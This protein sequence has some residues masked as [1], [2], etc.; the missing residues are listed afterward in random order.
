MDLHP[1]HSCWG[2]VIQQHLKAW[3]EQEP[4]L[5]AQ[6]RKRLYV[7]DLISSAPTVQETQQQKEKAIKIFS[8]A[9]FTLHKW[10][11]NAV[12]LEQHAKP[13]DHDEQSFA[14][15]QLGTKTSES[16]LL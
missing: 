12:E 6:I 5:V 8:D 13:E 7:N 11:S 2:G 1:R 10:K 14:K 16:K 4:E 9:Q 15:E 3:E